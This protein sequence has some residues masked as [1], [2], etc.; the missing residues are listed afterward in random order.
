MAKNDVLH[1]IDNMCLGG[2]QRI[3][4]TLVKDNPNHNL[5]SV[6]RAED[7]MGDFSDYTV[8]ESPSRFNVRS[9]IDVW[10]KLKEQNP[11]VVH[12]H[13]I[14][15][16]MIGIMLKILSRKDFKLV[17][18]EHG[19]IWKQ[20][21]R[22][23]SLLKYSSGLVDCHIAVS[24][25]T[26]KLLQ[27]EGD[28]PEDKIEVIYN[29]VDRGEYNPKVLDSFGS[30][31]SDRFDDEMFTVGFG[32]RLEE[33]KGWKTVV[34][35]AED[36]D[37]IRFLMSGSGT[38]EEELRQKAEEISN[39]HY[40]GYLDDVRTLFSSIDCFVLPSHWDPSPMVLYEVQSCGIT[41]ICSGA[42]SI[43]EL[44]ENQENALFFPSKDVKKLRK[45]LNLIKCN[46]G[47]REKLAENGISN[48]AIY[49]SDKYEKYLEKIYRNL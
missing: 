8:T 30:E 39:L 48:A 14:K 44:V 9:F 34:K 13:L 23:N 24:K 2:A 27:E 20:K 37:D 7:S 29:F 25:H 22:Y 31:L 17:L 3:V 45:C 26:A 41:L 5:H 47:L 32:G 43:D 40:L 28:V 18:H 12:C 15:S 49:S 35:A 16:K 38:G 4:S 46:P 1:V 6:R 21:Q 42:H 19:H 33:R 36:V 10:K 11:D